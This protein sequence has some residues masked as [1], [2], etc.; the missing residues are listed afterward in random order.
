MCCEY[1]P[2]TDT[3]TAA[4][5]RPA[6]PHEQP[7]QRART[8]AT[9]SLGRPS[10][11]VWLNLSEPGCARSHNT[12]ARIMDYTAIPRTSPTATD[13]PEC[14]ARVAATPIRSASIPSSIVIGGF[15][16]C[17]TFCAKFWSWTV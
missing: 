12:N 15:R 17:W 7:A 16:P 2:S 5:S 10:S 4:A 9:T 3:R 11:N 13:A 6:S 8:V 1:L 14:C